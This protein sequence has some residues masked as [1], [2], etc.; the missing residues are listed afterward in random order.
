MHVCYKLF[1]SYIE[2]EWKSHHQPISGLTRRCLAVV[3]I[4]PICV[5][6]HPSSP[7][8]NRASIHF[9][10]QIVTK[11]KY[12]FKHQNICNWTVYLTWE[13]FNNATFYQSP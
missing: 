5:S 13:T 1:S 8:L 10:L 11:V 2:T 7:A 12:L 3:R 4:S 6:Q 9:K